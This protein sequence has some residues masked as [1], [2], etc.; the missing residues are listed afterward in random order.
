MLDFSLSN[1]TGYEGCA[2]G[3]LEVKYLDK[4]WMSVGGLTE[5]WA[6]VLARAFV[7]KAGGPEVS[8]FHQAQWRPGG[9][10]F[11]EE[12]F[13][14]FTRLA[15]RTGAQRFAIVEYVGQKQ[16]SDF[17]S[18][19]FFR[20]SYP[21]DVS[22]SEIACSCAIADDVFMRPIRSY[23]VITDNGLAGKYVDSDALHPYEIVYGAN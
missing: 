6:G 11:T 21:L 7:L 12:E 20:F 1:I 10:L 14:E 15:S 8:F 5:N 16:W 9:V 13:A 2:L 4:Y 22:W 23:F 19:S 17:I 18:G 3:E